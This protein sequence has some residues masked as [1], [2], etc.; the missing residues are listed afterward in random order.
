MTHWRNFRPEEADS[1]PLQPGDRLRFVPVT[2][3]RFTDLA[4]DPRGGATREPWQ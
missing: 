4:A 1:L 2:Q 3:D